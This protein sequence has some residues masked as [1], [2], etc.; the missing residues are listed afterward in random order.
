LACPDA[1]YTTGS[2]IVVDGGLMLGPAEFD[3]TAAR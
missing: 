3:R 2:S 1:R